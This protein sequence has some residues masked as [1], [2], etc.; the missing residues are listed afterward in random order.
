M[1]AHSSAL[2]TP[3]FRGTK[4]SKPNLQN[5]CSVPS[6]SPLI[7]SLPYHHRRRKILRISASVSVSNP[8]VRTG[9]ADLVASI[10]SKVCPFPL[11]LLAL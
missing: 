10:L 8:E 4:H 1:A 11:S 7:V 2:L 3:S 9:P 6:N 5:S